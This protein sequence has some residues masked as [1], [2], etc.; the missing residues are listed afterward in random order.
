MVFSLS[1]W[2]CET[3]LLD[4]FMRA[5]MPERLVDDLDFF[6]LLEDAS[7]ETSLARL[8]L[9]VFD[10]IMLLGLIFDGETGGERALFPRSPKT[11]VFVGWA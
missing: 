10:V 5:N 2:I 4:L 8:S 9:L 6:G 7:P 1:F 3:S 11:F